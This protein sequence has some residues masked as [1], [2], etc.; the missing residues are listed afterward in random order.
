MSVFY[1]VVRRRNPQDS[2]MPD[3]F[4]AKNVAMGEITVGKLTERIARISTASRGDIFLVLTALVDEVADC[5]ENGQ[6][7]RLGE[8][9]SMRLSVS[10]SGEEELSKVSAQNIRKA[11]IIFTP[12]VGLKERIG[13]VNFKQQ[14][15]SQPAEPDVKPEEGGGGGEKPGEGGYE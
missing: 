14:V 10:S 6:T 1:K 9:G 4:Y 12:G 5:L 2:E 7:V 3:K 13:R 8:L 11:R 15:V